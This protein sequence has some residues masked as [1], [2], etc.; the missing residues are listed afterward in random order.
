M[1]DDCHKLNISSNGAVMCTA[2]KKSRLPYFLAKTT[3]LLFSS[4]QTPEGCDLMP[5]QTIHS[6]DVNPHYTFHA[7]P[8]ASPC[9]TTINLN[10]YNAHFTSTFWHANTKPNNPHLERPLPD[11]SKPQSARWQLH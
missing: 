6:T 8:D 7:K 2:K 11:C 5:K 4:F 3:C 9:F 1:K 10:P